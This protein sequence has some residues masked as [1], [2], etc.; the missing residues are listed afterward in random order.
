MQSN[1]NY[2]ILIQKLDEFIR[3]FYLN[4]LIRGVLFTAAILVSAYLLFSFLEYRFYFS[5]TVRKVLFYSFLGGA[6][7]LL[8]NNIITPLL[9]YNRLGKTINHKTAASIIG[10]HFFEI[11]DKL[12]NILELREQAEGTGNQLLI[13]AGINQKIEKIKPIPFSLAIDLN[14]NKKYLKYALPPLGVL[15]FVIFA[16]P[17][18][19]KDSNLRLLK[20][21]TFF[22]KAAPFNFLVQNK[23]LEVVQYE[24]FELKLQITMEQ[25]QLM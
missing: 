23:S 10:T 15:V 21:N 22:E 8:W 3:K 17:N 16:A 13:E 20:N 18:V 4:Q 1:S 25:E 5:T 9:K 14:K 19:L 12:L 2:H 24:D 7:F 11:Q 6:G